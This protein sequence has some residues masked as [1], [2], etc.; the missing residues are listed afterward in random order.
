MDMREQVQIAWRGVGLRVVVLCLF[1]EPVVLNSRIQ[2]VKQIPEQIL[3]ALA[4]K[5]S[6]PDST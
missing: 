2:S 1:Q 3:E 5:C 6:G 4:Q